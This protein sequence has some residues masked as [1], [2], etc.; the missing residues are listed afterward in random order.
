MLEARARV[1][2]CKRYEFWLDNVSLPAR[3]RILRALLPSVKDLERFE[4]RHSFEACLREVQ[5][6]FLLFLALWLGYNEELQVFSCN[7]LEAAPALVKLVIED[8]TPASLRDE[9]A[10]Q[11]IIA[12]YRTFMNW[13]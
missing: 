8:C 10:W 5:L 9:A 7:V 6:P 12:R 1:T 2:G 11:S 3:I 4:W 13:K